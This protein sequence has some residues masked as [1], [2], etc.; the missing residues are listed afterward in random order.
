MEPGLL[1]YIYCLVLSSS[2][3]LWKDFYDPHFA[4][5]EAEA[6]KKYLPQDYTAYKAQSQSVNRVQCHVSSFIEVGICLSG[7][8][9][10][11]GVRGFS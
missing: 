8:M 9:F 11:F 2:E 1:L 4:E 3:A 7:G 5:E 10:Q 6:Q